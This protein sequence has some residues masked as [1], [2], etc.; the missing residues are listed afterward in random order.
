MKFLYFT[1]SHIRGTAPKS[2]KDD[3]FQTVLNKTREIFRIAK[4]RDVDYMLHGG[5][6]FDRPD[7][8]IAVVGEFAKVLME[9]PCPLYIVSGNHDIYG[10]NPKTLSRTMLGFLSNLGFLELLND[11]TTILS[12]GDTKVQI[13]CAPYQF[14]MDKDPENKPYIVK[15][16]DESCDFAIHICHG[17]LIDQPMHHGIPHTLISDIIDTKADITLSGHLHHGFKTQYINGKYFINP[18]AIVR[19][20]NSLREIKRRPKVL[21]LECN[22]GAD[23]VIEEIYLKSA[24][25][26]DEVLD[27][28]EIEQHQFKKSKLHDFKEIVD[29]SGDFHKTDVFALLNEISD[30]EN[31][32][33]NVKEEA[34]QRITEVQMKREY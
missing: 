10:H 27:R 25:P 14:D 12:K 21:L 28:T 9:M 17:F 8:S 31:V 23:I 30:H 19:I 24:K 22:K 7:I 26:A 6:L 18:G 20:S 11:K 5:D 4:E 34:F 29:S 13:T 15:S 3:F 16:V 1:D 2:R 33:E 32:P